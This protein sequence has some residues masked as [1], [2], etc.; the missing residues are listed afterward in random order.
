MSL[1]AGCTI[2]TSVPPPAY[3][4]VVAAPPPPPLVEVRSAPKD[5]Q[6]LWIPG[7]WHWTGIQYAWIPG[8]WE[9]APPGT[10]WRR[11]QY[12]VREGV[13]VYEPGG[14]MRRP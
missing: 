10:R 14:W 9:I 7:Y 12:T 6:A 3:G 1:V 11:P 8:H 13:Y 2:E 4:M 5:P